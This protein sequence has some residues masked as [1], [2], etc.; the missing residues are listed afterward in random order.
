MSNY[1]YIKGYKEWAKSIGIC[2]NCF[3]EK[4]WNGRTMCPECLDKNKERSERTRTTESR[5]QRKRYVKR[6]RDLCVAFGICR[7]CL[8]KPVKKGLKCIEC[9]A[10]EL[11]RNE[12]KRKNVKRDMRVEL[13]LCYF[14]G[15]PVV[16]GKKTC[17]KHLKL[18]G[19]KLKKWHKEN[20]DN[21]NHHWRVMQSREIENLKAKHRKYLNRIDKLKKEFI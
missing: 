11:Q 4:A 8:K 5:E 7:E 17:E 13:G 1:E 6:K 3:S 12:K 14:C 19:D 15:E 10:K 9:Y 2:T 18:Q 16:K 21:S 20:G